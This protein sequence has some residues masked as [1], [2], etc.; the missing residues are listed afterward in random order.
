[1][2]TLLLIGAL[3][4]VLAT[5]APAVADHSSLDLEL[6]LGSRGFR[7]GGRLVGREGYAGGAWLNGEA[8][9][10]G[11]SLDGRVEHDGKTR[12]FKFDAT[13][14]EWLGRALRWGI[15]DL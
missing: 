12:T 6:R 11:F 7:L 14:D 1:M 8:R 2:K 13:I 3:G 5:T 4:T 9:R 10:D 15:T